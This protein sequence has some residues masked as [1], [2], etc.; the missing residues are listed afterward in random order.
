MTI[1][2]SSKDILITTDLKVIANQFY[3]IVYCTHNRYKFITSY[4]TTV[5]SASRIQFYKTL[6]VHTYGVV[7]LAPSI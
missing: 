7:F 6:D 1:N 4:T 5:F 2:I 3:F